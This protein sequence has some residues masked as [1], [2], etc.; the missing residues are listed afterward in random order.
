[1]TGAGREQAAERRF[2]E[3]LAERGM[4]RC[5]TC[6]RRIDRGDVAW[7]NGATEYGTPW[8]MVQIICQQC[9]TEIAHVLSWWPEIDDFPE[10]V[11]WVLD[12]KDWGLR[13]G[14]LVRGQASARCR[15]HPEE[16]VSLGAGM[17]NR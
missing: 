4:E 10:A 17:V 16:R 11:E 15:G 13:I 12:S 9:D 6:G 3:L 2:G 1:M 14:V 7:T 5:P 8:S